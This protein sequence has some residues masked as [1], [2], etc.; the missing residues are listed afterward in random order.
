MALPLPKSAVDKG[1]APEYKQVMTR[2]VFKDAVD[3]VCTEVF[4]L[5][6]GLA[7]EFASK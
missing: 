3:T 4:R 5:V 7:A 6:E 2:P 1:I